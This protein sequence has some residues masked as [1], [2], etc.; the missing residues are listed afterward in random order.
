MRVRD[1]LGGFVAIAVLL[2]STSAG[3]SAAELR[4]VEVEDLRGP[5]G[6]EWP[7]DSVVSPDGAYVYSVV[8]AVPSSA[9]T[10]RAFARAPDGSLS[11]IGEPIPLGSSSYAPHSLAMSP[12]GQHLYVGV[13]SDHLLAL[14]RDPS[15]GLLTLLEHVG[16]V[17]ANLA[18]SPDGRNVYATYP[19]LLVTYARETTS[20]LLTVVDVEN[21]VAG[22]APIEGAAG[23]A[24]SPDG[25]HVYLGSTGPLSSGES[26]HDPSLIVF[27]RDQTTGAL[28]FVEAVFDGQNGVEGLSFPAKVTVS[29][30]GHHVYASGSIDGDA[31][32][33]VMF[34]R[35]ATNG[36]LA[37]LGRAS[38]GGFS[39]DDNGA[40]AVSPDG[41][42]VLVTGRELDPCCFRD[43]FSVFRRDVA[44][45]LLTHLETLVRQPGFE[46]RDLGSTTSIAF[47]PDGRDVYVTAGADAV[48]TAYRVLPRCSAEPLTGCHLPTREHRSSIVLT[49]GARDA[50]VWKWR[51]GTATSGADLG[52][53]RATTDYAFCLHRE[54]SG[55]WDDALQLV[56]PAASRCGAEEL[57]C[58]RDLGNPAAPEGYLLRDDA[59]QHDGVTELRLKPHVDGR[60]SILLRGGGP[61]LDRPPL[62]LGPAE[63]IVAQLRTGDGACWSADY[64]APA[65]QDGVRRFAD[66][67]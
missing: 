31:D 59:G 29:P 46:A 33:V 44:T 27:A 41:E 37:F 5:S 42:R 19:S 8:S 7:W 57:P 16:D 58:W 22:P 14:A 1:S 18:P 34:S 12:D 3:V 61:A 56:V 64:A 2:A 53:P 23:I 50:L 38:G 67:D 25:R 26:G 63:R 20:G 45:G 55:S 30:E 10:V 48:V 9:A 28:D 49:G 51:R 36:T 13:G 6:A 47:G 40:I 62:P 35:E 4:K 60:V 11:P 65:L 24:V 52:D 54:T 32:G 15:S 39:H 21:G 17:S 66:R 43:G